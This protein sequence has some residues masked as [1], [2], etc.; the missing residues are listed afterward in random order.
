MDPTE[1]KKYP[2]GQLVSHLRRIQTSRVRTRSAGWE[3]IK[4]KVYVAPGGIV[5]CARIENELATADSGS[6]RRRT[7]KQTELEL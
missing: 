5:K 3:K 6:A 7:G 4:E 1:R 2:C